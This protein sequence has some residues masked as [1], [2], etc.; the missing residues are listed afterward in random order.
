MADKAEAKELV[1][2]DQ[3]I[4]G[5]N[6][7][8]K[9]LAI[10]A[11]MSVVQKGLEVA[12]KTNKDGSVAKSY[13]AV[14]ERDILDTV[15]PLEAKYH[16]YSYPV[17]RDIVESDVI[18][19]TTNYGERNSF[20]MRV[21]VGYRFVNADNPAE[22]ITIT[23]Y[24]DGIDTGDKAPGKAMTY[25][26]KYALMKAY[27]ISTG[28]DP[29][30]EASKEYQKNSGKLAVEYET[31]RKNLESIGVDIMDMKFVGY[32][33]DNARVQNLDPKVLLDDTAATRRVIKVMKDIYEVKSRENKKGL[34]NQ[35]STF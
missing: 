5:M 31:V 19:T 1:T 9:L 28:D 4:T 6:I 23:S 7:Y 32:V 24:G 8:Q 29:D 15:K 17:E 20:Y 14:S 13:K 10:T 34:Y 12:T 22:D 16:I 33:C 18:K 3:K 27:K 21:R 11:E 35:D 25:A 2:E 30:Q 26:D